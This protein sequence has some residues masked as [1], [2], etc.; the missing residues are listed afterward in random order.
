MDKPTFD[1]LK[2]LAAQHPEAFERLR[3][4]LIEDCICSSSKCSQSRLRGLQ[5]VIDARRS[6]ANNPVKALLEI[7]GMMYESLHRLNRALHGQG[8]KHPAPEA[9]LLG[10]PKR[11]PHHNHPPELH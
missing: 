7:Q 3:S 2:N 11:W 10:D 1:E 4:E 5:F 8:D 9:H 6:L